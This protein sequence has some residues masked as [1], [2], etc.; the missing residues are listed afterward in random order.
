MVLIYDSNSDGEEKANIS[1]RSGDL[2]PYE[3]YPNETSGGG[4]AG[5]GAPMVCIIS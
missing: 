2:S 3:M 5:D 1:P 4:G